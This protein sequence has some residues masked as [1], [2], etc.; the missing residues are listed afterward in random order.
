MKKLVFRLLIVGLMAIVFSQCDASAQQFW[1][2]TKYGMASAVVK[3]LFGQKIHNGDT[4]AKGS[5]SLQ[6]TTTI[7]DVRFNVHFIFKNDKLI[8]TDLDGQTL[9]GTTPCILTQYYEAYGKPEIAEQGELGR[10]ILFKRGDTVLSI[11]TT[12]LTSSTDR[13]F[14]AYRIKRTDL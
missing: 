9:P 11:S 1:G 10:E 3:Q 13:I 4:G 2:K 14:I 5:T 7:C 8:E 6:M 12:V